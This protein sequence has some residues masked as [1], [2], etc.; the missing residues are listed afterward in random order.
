L[1]DREITP[2]V[3]GALAFSGATTDETK[4]IQ[5]DAA[6]GNYIDLNAN[7]PYASP[8]YFRV[9]QDDAGNPRV[10]PYNEYTT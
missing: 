3:R 1:S 7:W 6:A 9:T 8:A 4:F 10:S 5:A 2:M